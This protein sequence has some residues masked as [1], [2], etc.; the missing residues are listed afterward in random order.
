MR[1]AAI[2]CRV[3]TLDQSPETQG[4]ELR[5]FAVQ[6]SYQIIEEYIDHG[7][8]GTKV[9]C[10]ALDR[11]LKDAQRRKFDAVLVWSCDRLARS[12][13]HFLEVLD[14]LNELGIRFVSQRESIDTDGPLGRAIVTILS[15]IAELERSLIMERVSAG[16][17]R[18]KL[19]GRRIMSRVKWADAG[20]VS[21]STSTF[22]QNKVRHFP[23]SGAES[24]M[25][26][27]QRPITWGA[28]IDGKIAV[29]DPAHST[30]STIE[31]PIFPRP[32]QLR[33]RRVV[34]RSRARTTGKYPSWKMERM[35]Q[36]ESINE[37][38]AFMLLDCDPRVR[39]FSEQPCVIPFTMN[40]VRH[41]HYPDIL[42]ETDGSTEFWE[43]KTE[44]DANLAEIVQR[45]TLLAR[46]LVRYGYT[47]RL[48][49][50]RDLN[51]ASRLKNADTL[52]RFGCHRINDIDR[53][54][55]RAR[56]RQSGCIIWHDAC[57][58]TYGHRGRQVL[59]RLVLEG[60]VE[61]DL[62][63]LPSPATRFLPRVGY[64]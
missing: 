51:D 4:L 29:I 18:M 31:A 12:T 3:S 28:P 63:L 27:N 62:T 24:S 37:R 48:V 44:K 5:Q 42:V 6:R 40:G 22:P 35:L 49:L 47:Y 33:A 10:P 16:M 21:R 9:R 19:E 61:L 8:S 46:G 32:G 2:Y 30:V 53:E 41:L 13:K 54:H 58:G 23:G 60:H 17:R 43:V 1:S 39:R 55:I 52:L 15:A 38:N 57:V 26:G 50:D 59:C 25:Q 14:E 34:T 45:T 36:W 7:V 11:L 20:R 56:F 64:L